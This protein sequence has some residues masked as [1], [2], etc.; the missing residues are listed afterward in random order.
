[1]RKDQQHM[2]SVEKT[3]IILCTASDN[4]IKRWYKVYNTYPII[5]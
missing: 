1:M 2:D 5:H 3:K 4:F